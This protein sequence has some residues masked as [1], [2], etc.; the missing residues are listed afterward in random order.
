MRYLRK[1]S[2]PMVIIGW[3]SSDVCPGPEM[4]GSG[5][6]NGQLADAAGVNLQTLRH[7]ERLQSGAEATTQV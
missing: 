3:P 2:S 4:T 1:P 5:L 7:Y 6:R